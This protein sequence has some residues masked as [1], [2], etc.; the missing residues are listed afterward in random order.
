MIDA[1]T[2]RGFERRSEGVSEGTRTPD[3]RDHKPG[4]PVALSWS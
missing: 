1:A 3:R 2:L 4:V